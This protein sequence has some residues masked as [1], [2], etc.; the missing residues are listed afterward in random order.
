MSRFITLLFSLLISL[1]NACKKD[2]P[3]PSVSMFY[4]KDFRLDGLPQKSSYSNVSLT[5]QIVLSFSAPVNRSS[6]P[7]QI[8]LAGNSVIPL[9]ISY[10][11]SDST[12]T[13][14][15]VNPLQGWTNY[16]FV[17]TNNVHSV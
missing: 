7:G 9:T 8:V 13:I 17:I 16:G 2:N 5:P 11:N 12:V 10:S 6:I 14:S 15:T 4:L 1:L 3:P